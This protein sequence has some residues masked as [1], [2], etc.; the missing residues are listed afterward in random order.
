M[1]VKNLQE[2]RSAW[3]EE[4]GY[5]MP[6][7]DE[8][9]IGSSHQNTSGFYKMVNGIVGN[10]KADLTPKLQN[11][12]DEQAIYE[13]LQNAADSQST[14][15]AVLYDEDYFM[16]LNNGKPFSN[17][18]VKAI[19]NTFQGTKA[20]KSRSKIAIKSVVMVSVLS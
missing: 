15:C 12:Q 18:D 4:Q 10:I 13:F 14:A 20:D 1:L 2:F 3:K 6:N 9:F 11:A 16:V 8:N 7:W 19:L 17:N 5:N